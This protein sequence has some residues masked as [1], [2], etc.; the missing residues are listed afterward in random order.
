MCLITLFPIE[1]WNLIIRNLHGWMARLSDIWRKCQKLLRSNTTISQVIM[2]IWL[3]QQV[4]APGSIWNPKRKTVL[5]WVLRP[6]TFEVFFKL[7]FILNRLIALQK[8]WKY[9]I[10][11]KKLFLFLRYSTFCISVLLSSS[12]CQPLL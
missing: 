5:H 10:S 4:N 7:R 9:L 1:F 2:N 8:L 6:S 11:S 3:I 12:S